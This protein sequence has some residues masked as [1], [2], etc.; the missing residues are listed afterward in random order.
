MC[1]LSG[2]LLDAM[3][4]PIPTSPLDHPYIP[5][6]Y[7]FFTTK[8]NDRSTKD[9]SASTK[10]QTPKQMNSAPEKKYIFHQNK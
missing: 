2:F 10:F 1:P 5:L 3:C 9:N 4:C 7:N 6:A 8:I